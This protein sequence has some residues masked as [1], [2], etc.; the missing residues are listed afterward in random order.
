MKEKTIAE[1]A[2]EDGSTSAFYAEVH[3]VVGAL[4]DARNFFIALLSHDGQ[5][6]EFPYFVDDKDAKK[7][8]KK[9]APPA[10]KGA[11]VAEEKKAE[12]KPEEVPEKEP[13]APAEK[14]VVAVE[15][16]KQ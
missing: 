13:E 2:A 4:L 12:E 6:L 3:A 10:K 9:K 15:A 7:E 11:A 16:S 1:L 8:T 5:Q 14:K